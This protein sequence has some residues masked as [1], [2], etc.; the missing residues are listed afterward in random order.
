[1]VNPSQADRD[2][3]SEGDHCDVNDGAMYLMFHTSSNLQWQPEPDYEAWN[4]YSGDLEV[5]RATGDYTQQPGSN[6]LADRHCGLPA[7]GMDNP[8][9]PPVGRA[10]FLLVTGVNAQGESALGHDSS[11]QPRPNANPCP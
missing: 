9:V 8:L 7:A 2:G 1:M 5:L 11:G 3:D 10:M 4:C 6:P